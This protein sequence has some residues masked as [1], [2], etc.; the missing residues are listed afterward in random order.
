M[1]MGNGSRETRENVIGSC[2]RN[3]LGNRKWCA[4]LI[5]N[6]YTDRNKRKGKDE[7]RGAGLQIKKNI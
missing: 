2:E 6:K 5:E 4:E 1:K 7:I 3:I